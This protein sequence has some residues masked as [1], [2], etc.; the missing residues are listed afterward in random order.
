MRANLPQREPAIVARWR[1]THL[2]EAAAAG[3]RRQAE[4]RAARRAA[5]RQRAC[6]PRHRA[7]QDHQRHRREVEGDGR[8]PDA[9]CPR[10]GLPRHADRASSD[11]GSRR[12]GARDVAARHA[13]PLPRLRGEVLR[14]PARGV[15]APRRARRLGPPVPHDGAA[16][17]KRRSSTVF[18]QLVEGGYI[19][20]G[21][22]PVH[23]CAVCATALAE[24]EVEY[25]DHTSPSIY[26]KFRVHRLGR[27]GA[28]MAVNPARRRRAGRAS[29]AS[30]RR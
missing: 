1:E 20:R 27:R 15:P 30:S 2:Y 13:P 12:Q 17:T 29:P 5:V 26:V 16:T 25:S 7:Q 22:R 11:Q 28:A 8:V 14:H 3:Q 23:W 19:Y 24:A 21:L 10:L 9:V 18:R 4:V 6:P